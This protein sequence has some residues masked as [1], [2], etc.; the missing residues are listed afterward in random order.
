MIGIF[1]MA[2]FENHQ[3][4]RVDV[5]CLCTRGGSAKAAV[6]SLYLYRG[7]VQDSGTLVSYQIKT[8][9]AVLRLSFELLG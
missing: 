6:A 8:L 5:S 9:V 7:A 3:L 4:A 2:L 1:Q